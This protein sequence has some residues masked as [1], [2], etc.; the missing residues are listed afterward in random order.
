MDIFSLNLKDYV[1]AEKCMWIK[2]WLFFIY[3]K[4]ML[5]TYFNIHFHLLFY[6]SS[7]E[8]KQYLWPSSH[9]LQYFNISPCV[10]K[11][12]DSKEKRVE[13]RVQW[14]LITACG[15][16][17]NTLIILSKRRQHRRGL[18]PTTTRVREALVV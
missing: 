2:K 18:Q 11:R 9:L 7:K 10:W 13:Q 16:T 4:K 17:I 5:E 12:L 3:I 8:I 6:L 15:E 1:I 14:S